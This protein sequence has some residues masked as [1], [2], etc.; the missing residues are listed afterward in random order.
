MSKCHFGAPMVDH[1]S[2]ITS[3]SLLPR[4]DLVAQWCLLGRGNHLQGPWGLEHKWILEHNKCYFDYEHDC[5]FIV[6]MSNH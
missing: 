2:A 1:Y 4:H 6:P 3:D 5:D